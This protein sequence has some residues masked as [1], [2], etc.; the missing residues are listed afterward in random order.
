VAETRFQDAQS[1]RHPDFSIRVRYG[2]HAAAALPQGAHAASD[3]YQS[4]GRGI[5]DWKIKER[6]VVNR[7]TLR[8]SY[9]PHILSTPLRLRSKLRHLT[10][11]V[12]R[13]DHRK[14]G[15]QDSNCQQDWR[16]PFEKRFQPQPE[17]K[18]DAGVYP[19]DRE[20]CKLY[21]NQ[22]RPI[23]PDPVQRRGIVWGIAAKH[24]AGNPD[25]S[26]MIGKP[27]R[28][29]QAKH[30]LRNL[31]GG[32]AKVSTLIAPTDPTQNVW[33]LRCRA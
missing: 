5:A 14:R 16:R 11:A 31:S 22:I 23:D 12:V 26:K 9:R 4:N 24:D 19:C 2:K 30:Q 27:E 8:R 1:F 17:I 28:N 25:P 10:R 13:A 6:N 33:R 21:K 18:S 32:K 3:K 7:E 20:K 29:A 15:Q